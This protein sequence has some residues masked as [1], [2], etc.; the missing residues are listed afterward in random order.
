[1]LFCG[2]KLSKKKKNS[3]RND[4]LFVCFEKIV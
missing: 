1:M 3:N 2:A 4:K